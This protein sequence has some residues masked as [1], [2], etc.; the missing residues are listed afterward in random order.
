MSEPLGPHPIAAV[1]ARLG[2]WRFSLIWIIPIVTAAI[3]AWLAWDT[4]SQ[5]GPLVTISFRAAEG[6]QAGQSHVRYKAVDMGL[7]E[8]VA[9]TPDLQHVA[10]TVRMTREAEPLLTDHAQFWV[11]KPRF[12]AGAVSGLETLFSGAYIGLAVTSLGGETK[13]DFT[14]LEDPPV[15]QS[16]EPGHTF[17]L[18]SARI[19]NINVGSPVYYRDLTVGEVL[20]WDVADMADSVTLHVFV[21]TPYDRYVHDGTRFWN[22]S[23]A[24]V[25][26]GTS[27]LEFQLE[28]LRALVLGGIAFDTPVEAR[29][30]PVSSENHQYPLYANKDAA[31]AASYEQRVQMLAYFG[32][33]VAGLGVGA[34]VTLRG[35]RIGEVVAVSLRYDPS[36]DNVVV[37]VEFNVEPER[38]AQWRVQPTG[39][40]LAALRELVQRGL[41]VRLDSTSLLTGQKQLTID[42]YPNT[43]PAEVRIEGDRAVIPTLPSGSDDIMSSASAILAKLNAMPFE[44]IGD[45]LNGALQGL[46]GV[47]NSE[48][49]RQSLASLQTTL[50]GTQDLVKRL[51][52][53]LDPALQRLPEVA[54]GLEDS[55]RRANRLIA[56]LDAGYG[57]NSTFSRDIDRMM[58][59]LTDTARSVRVLADLLARHPE[60]L[61]RGR[62]D[63]GP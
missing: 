14:G 7:V 23:G 20:G 28:S 24:T 41:R 10:V 3:G 36:T 42:I 8:R 54:A 19:G 49:L 16:D 18:R 11:V 56:S 47:A 39:N 38:I 43:P 26:L 40:R 52:A 4:L 55:V 30:S 9:L 63:Q 25:K 31:D 48:Q 21:R 51:N 32:G 17:L 57:G 46:S 15:L 6:L 45:N 62:T 60:A 22:A 59:Q 50:A 13:H 12:F 33:S 44:Q 53:G 2:D 1:R 37:P 5:R 58:L 27:G 29:N 35:I 34:P 61:I